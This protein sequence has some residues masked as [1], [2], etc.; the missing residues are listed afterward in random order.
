MSIVQF[1]EA[2][3]F[4]NIFG[5]ANGLVIACPDEQARE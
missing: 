4:F 2:N 1:S 3:Y 5:E